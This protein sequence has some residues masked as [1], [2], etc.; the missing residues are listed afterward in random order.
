M[1]GGINAIRGYLFQY[2]ICILD[3]FQDAWSSVIIEPSAAEDK[4]DILWFF[5]IDSR[6][7]KKAV[8]VKST[9]N[10]FGKPEAISIA[11]DLRNNFKDADSY[12]LVLIGHASSPLLEYLKVSEEQGVRILYPKVFDLEAFKGNACH[13]IDKYLEENYGTQ[14]PWYQLE[15]LVF[16]LLGEL[17]YYSTNKREVARDEFENKLLCWV[18]S[19]VN[20]VDYELQDSRNFR[21]LYG[22]DASPSLRTAINKFFNQS[23]KIRKTFFKECQNFLDIEL[24]S[25]TLKVIYPHADMMFFYFGVFT[26]VIASIPTIAFLVLTVYVHWKFVFLVLVCFPLLLMPTSFVRPYY[27]AKKIDKELK[28]LYRRK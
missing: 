10:Q 11:H 19:H 6:V 28:E 13:K 22:F 16:S 5:K 8:Q 9:Q 23:R 3:S 2:L 4:V 25:K 12:E 15:N 21:R 1:N 17:Q 18:K 24:N 26:Q 14:L 27:L 7:Y 20:F